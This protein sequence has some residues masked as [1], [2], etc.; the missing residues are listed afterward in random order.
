MTLQQLSILLFWTGLAVIGIPLILSIWH[1]QSYM[2]MPP[3]E[4]VDEG[5]DE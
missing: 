1:D 2:D 3:D 5:E 4:D